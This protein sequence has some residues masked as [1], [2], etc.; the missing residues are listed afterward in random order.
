[1]MIKVGKNRFLFILIKYNLK[2]S[3][4]YIWKK[5]TFDLKYYYGSFV[6]LS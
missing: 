4:I 6:I 1:M 2:S 5:L 3:I